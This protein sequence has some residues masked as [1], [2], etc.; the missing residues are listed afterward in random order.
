[1]GEIEPLMSPSYVDTA[2]NYPPLPTKMRH[3]D[4]EGDIDA[5]MGEYIDKLD[6]GPRL[7]IHNMTSQVAQKRAS[8]KEKRKSAKEAKPQQ[9]PSIKE[10]EKPPSPTNGP[11]MRPS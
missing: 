11:P 3:A 7:S 6:R 4:V 8:V 10:L 1:M 9:K 5:E 2:V